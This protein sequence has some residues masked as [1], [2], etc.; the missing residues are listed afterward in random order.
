MADSIKDILDK[1]GVLQ[2][3]ILPPKIP[4][5]L[6]ALEPT[7]ALIDRLTKGMGLQRVGEVDRRHEQEPDPP[8]RFRAIGSYGR[9]RADAAGAS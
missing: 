4:F 9:R 3:V 5:L 1:S 8:I 6:S 2:H 7:A